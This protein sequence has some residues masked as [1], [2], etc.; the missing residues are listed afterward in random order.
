M[1]TPVLV[2]LLIGRPGAAT[3]YGLIQ[4][5]VEMLLGNPFG[6]MAILYAGLEGLGTDLALAA[7][8]YR[9]TLP[10]ALVAGALGNLLIDEVYL[11]LFG[12]AT[13][14][15]IIVGGITAAVSGA[16]LGGLIAWLIVKALQQTGVISRIGLKGYQELS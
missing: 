5:F 10:A 16:V 9:P 11:F 12:L 7:F 3:V 4:G 13:P 2:G 15:N 1:I 14:S 6:A 8:R